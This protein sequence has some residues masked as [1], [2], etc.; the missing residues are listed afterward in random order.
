MS[1][2]FVYVVVRLHPDYKF[3]EGV[4]FVFSTEKE[5]ND[6]IDGIRYHNSGNDIY[7]VVKRDLF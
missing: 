2:K 7:K 4:K 5:A 3:I 6:Y 1:R